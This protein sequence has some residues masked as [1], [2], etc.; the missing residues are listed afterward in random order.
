VARVKYLLWLRDRIGIGEEHVESKTLSELL[1]I[2]ASKYGELKELEKRGSLVVLING[3]AVDPRRNVELSYE[4][5]VVLLP[6]VSG[7]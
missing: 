4:D 3:L 1:E 7:G 6:E 5:E 2:L